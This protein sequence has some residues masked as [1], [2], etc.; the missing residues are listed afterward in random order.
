VPHQTDI[1]ELEEIG[2]FPHFETPEIVLE[3]F[4]EF[5]SKR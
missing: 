4:F 3:K 1:V 5:H 2:H